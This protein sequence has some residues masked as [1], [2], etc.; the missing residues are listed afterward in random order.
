[1]SQLLMAVALALAL[2]GCGPKRP[3]PPSPAVP[4]LC[5][6]LCYVPCDTQA[7]AWTP[8]DPDS[9]EAWRELGEQVIAPLVGQLTQCEAGRRACAQC[10]ERHKASGVLL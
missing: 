1:M 6:A 10:I 4:A 7:P 8:R 3:G 5:N 9:P 2:A